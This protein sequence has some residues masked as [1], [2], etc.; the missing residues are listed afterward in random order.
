MNRYTGLG[1]AVMFLLAIGFMQSPFAQQNSNTRPATPAA[2][3]AD[4]EET[5]G[6]VPEFLANLPEHGAASIW[7]MMKELEL[8]PDT[9]LGSKEK[10]LIGL[11]VAAQIPC[12]YC[13]YA[14]T[15]GALAFGA[16]E[17][18]IG[19]ALAMAAYTRMGSTMLNGLA[20]D[21]EQFKA[22][23]DRLMSGED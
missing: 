16:T 6:F 19:E 14:Y 20:A 10:A 4:I 21:F 3:L 5:L 22:D 2:I 9:A 11:A 7:A 18:E 1:F 8:N 15:Q 17:Q 13:I 12:E 23:I